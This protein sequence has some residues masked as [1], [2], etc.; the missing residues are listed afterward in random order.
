M[1]GLIKNNKLRVYSERNPDAN[2][3]DKKLVA[4]RD[5]LV[6]PMCRAWLHKFKTKLK[7][8]SYSKHYFYKRLI[9]D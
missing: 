1:L 9:R 2:V 3:I 5:V 8:H 4:R 6:N 7:K